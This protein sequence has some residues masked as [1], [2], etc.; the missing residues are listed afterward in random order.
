M[1]CTTKKHA[2][3]PTFKQSLPEAYRNL[4]WVRLIGHH[5]LFTRNPTNTPQQRKVRLGTAKRVS[6]FIADPTLAVNVKKQSV[7]PI[8]LIPNSLCELLFNLVFHYH[9]RRN[10]QILT[11][12]FIILISLVICHPE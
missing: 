4:P 10:I 1:N 7:H 8:A 9:C 12:R 6:N 11:S 3:P 5:F 2:S